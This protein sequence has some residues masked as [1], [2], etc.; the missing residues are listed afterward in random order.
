M[1]PTP[2]K[3]N[4]RSPRAKPIADAGL[5]WHDEWLARQLPKEDEASMPGAQGA[6]LAWMELPAARKRAAHDT[7][8]HAL[9]DAA[10]GLLSSSQAQA[11]LAQFGLGLAL[12]FDDPHALRG[13]CALGAR[14]HPTSLER[15]ESPD[16]AECWE[17]SLLHQCASKRRWATLAELA[18]SPTGLADIALC[19]ALFNDP[20]PNP[21]RSLDARLLDSAAKQRSAAQ[22]LLAPLGPEADDRPGDDSLDLI[23]FGS[24]LLRSLINGHVQQSEI[25]DM[26]IAVSTLLR[27]SPLFRALS[28]V[29]EHSRSVHGARSASPDPRAAEALDALESAGLWRPAS[30]AHREALSHLCLH[31]TPA[32]CS[33]AAR[34][35]VSPS[36]VS[37]HSQE[38]LMNEAAIHGLADGSS[39]SDFCKPWSQAPGFAD[40]MAAF[41]SRQCSRSHRDALAESVLKTP[42]PSSPLRGDC[43]RAVRAMD[44]FA[45]SLASADPGFAQPSPESLAAASA[46]LD[47]MEIEAFDRHPPLKWAAETRAAA[48]SLAALLLPS[49]PALRL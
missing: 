13:F 30:P 29:A 24:D 40:R 15:A 26:S 28:L 9:H 48:A 18:G 43:H 42:C 3:K 6:L 32:V 22:Q 36:D 7:A 12:E 5:G 37:A 34:H 19:E 10:F 44:S 31:D 14:V 20:Q 25:L 27:G 47:A 11:E 46:L 38:R 33:W 23:D 21:L 4:A 17:A 39:F 35:G 41:L 45:K 8:A 2:K 16:Y 1:N 49:K